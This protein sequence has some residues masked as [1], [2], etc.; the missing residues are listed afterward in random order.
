MRSRW[1]VHALLNRSFDHNYLIH[2]YPQ[3]RF[4][5]ATT[6]DD[7]QVNR[8]IDNFRRMMGCFSLAL[9]DLNGLE[10]AAEW[11]FRLTRASN[12]I[13]IAQQENQLV[14]CVS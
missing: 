4:S 8:I 3:A 6:N 11:P 10:Y 5:C 9:S 12:E 14:V 1:D 13:Q 2:C 7:H